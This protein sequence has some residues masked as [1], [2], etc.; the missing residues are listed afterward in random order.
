MA[1][2]LHITNVFIFLIK[3]VILISNNLHFLFDRITL[4]N[5]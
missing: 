3:N 4:I 2:N 5:K 1:F